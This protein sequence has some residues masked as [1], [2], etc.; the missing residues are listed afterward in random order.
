MTATCYP[1]LAY[2]QLGADLWRILDTKRGV[3]VGPVYRSRAELLADLD[4]FAREYGVYSTGPKLLHPLE[5]YRN[6]PSGDGP[7]AAQWKDKPH[8]LLYDLCTTLE[9]AG[10]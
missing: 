10:F 8:R 4:R 1:G 9:Q 5:D 2:A 7:L 3:A 6:A